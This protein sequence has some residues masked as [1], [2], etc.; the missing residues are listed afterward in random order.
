VRSIYYPEV[1]ELVEKAT[2]AREVVALERDVRCT[3]KAWL[4]MSSVHEPVRVVHDDYTEKS[5]PERVRLYLPGKPTP[6]S[7]RIIR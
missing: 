1:G 6:Y 5:S 4:G 3:P 2:G 7:S